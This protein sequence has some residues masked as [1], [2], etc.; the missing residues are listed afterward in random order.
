MLKTRLSPEA[1]PNVKLNLITLTLPRPV[2]PN[3]WDTNCYRSIDSL[4][5]GRRQK[6]MQMLLKSISVLF[7]Y[8]QILKEVLILEN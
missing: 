6:E 3:P 1:L 7:I 8:F 2:F 5:P 4:V